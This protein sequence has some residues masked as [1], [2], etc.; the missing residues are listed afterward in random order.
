MHFLKSDV[1]HMGDTFI[2]GRYP[3]VDLSSGGNVNGFVTA[4]DRALTICNS[5]TKIIPGHGTLSDCEGLRG[6][7][8]MIATVRERVR[9][10]MR[11]GKSLDTIKAAK[12]TRDY[13][14]RFARNPSWTPDMFI[15]AVYRSLNSRTAKE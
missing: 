4:A 15:E 10:A 2:T 6:W 11:D 14:P 9:V 12:L 7:R 1:I 8:D 3:F 5:E 13:D